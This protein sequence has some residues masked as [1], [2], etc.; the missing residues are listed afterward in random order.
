[1][2]RVR[3]AMTKRV[4][5]ILLLAAGCKEAPPIGPSPDAGHSS[6][7][8][9]WEGVQSIEPNGQG[10]LAR[11]ELENASGGQVRGVLQV[12][13][14]MDANDLGT[15]GRLAGPAQG[16]TFA[17]GP[18]RP[19][20]GFETQYTMTV[21]ASPSLNHIDMVEQHQVPDGGPFPVYYRMDR[22]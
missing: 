11:M 20:G 5:W 14:E 19:D 13:Y 2:L 4:L 8:G 18:Y 7:A 3:L 21:T 9:K 10:N 12:S 17:R 22:Q 15:I 16:G 6:L 1:V